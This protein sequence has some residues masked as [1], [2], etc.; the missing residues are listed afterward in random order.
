MFY[1]A[2]NSSLVG[3]EVYDRPGLF[4]VSG[5]KD[6]DNTDSQSKVK[7]QLSIGGSEA[8]EKEFDLFEISKR[9]HLKIK[10]QNVKQMQK[11]LI[12]NDKDSI[13]DFYQ[14]SFQPG[15]PVDGHVSDYSITCPDCG[16]GGRIEID[17]PLRVHMQREF[18]TQQ[19]VLEMMSFGRLIFQ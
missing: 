13:D 3:Y 10:T 4:F 15:F 19:M 17:Y 18:A 1:F 16:L 12:I 6:E 8:Q 5:Y 7:F 9:S 11:A 2:C 14:F